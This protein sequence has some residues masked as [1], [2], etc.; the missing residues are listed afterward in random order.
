MLSGVG[1]NLYEIHFGIHIKINIK[2][3][4]NRIGFAH[5]AISL[6]IKSSVSK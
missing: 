5:N 3:I 4:T 6:R 1:V 2:Q